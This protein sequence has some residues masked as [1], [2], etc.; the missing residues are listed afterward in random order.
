MGVYVFACGCVY[1]SRFRSNARL[2]RCSH[3]IRRMGSIC[4]TPFFPVESTPRAKMRD[5][6]IAPEV[7][8]SLARAMPVRGA[9]S[10]MQ[11]EKRDNT[12]AVLLL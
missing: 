9:M 5:A 2:S 7:N 4:R 12:V 11:A 1:E 6:V 3:V 8:T 10:N